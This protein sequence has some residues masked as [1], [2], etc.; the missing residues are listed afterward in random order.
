MEHG[1][2]LFNACCARTS[3]C[4]VSHDLTICETASSAA[5]PSPKSPMIATRVPC[6]LPTAHVASSRSAAACV[7]SIF[8]STLRIITQQTDE[9]CY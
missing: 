9:R 7:H 6:T 4:G 5:L 2:V 8:P 3:G 1:G